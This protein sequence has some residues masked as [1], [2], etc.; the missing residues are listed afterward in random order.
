MFNNIYKIR[1]AIHPSLFFN[2][3]VLGVQL[4]QQRTML[5]KIAPVVENLEHQQVEFLGLFAIHFTAYILLLIAHVYTFNAGLPFIKKMTE[6]AHAAELKQPDF[7]KLLVAVRFEK[8]V[9]FFDK[10]NGSKFVF[11]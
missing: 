2:Y 4:Q 10:Q 5:M 1:R 6:Q 7:V 11:D 3:F 8:D 9:H